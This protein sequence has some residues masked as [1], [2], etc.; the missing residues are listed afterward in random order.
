MAEE[1]DAMTA[2]AVRALYTQRAY[3]RLSPA[4]LEQLKRAPS[5]E[6]L[7][8]ILKGFCVMACMT[9]AAWRQW[10]DETSDDFYRYVERAISS[11]MFNLLPLPRG[12]DMKVEIGPRAQAAM[13]AT[14]EVREEITDV[15]A[16]IRQVLDDAATGKFASQEEALLSLGGKFVSIDEIDLD[17]DDEKGTLQ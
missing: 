2:R 15:I 4:I 11:V 1:E 12:E 3:D 9:A 5:E 7:T 16:R 13:D 6:H 17:E 8:L 10:P 14:P